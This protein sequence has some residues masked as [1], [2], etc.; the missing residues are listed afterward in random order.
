MHPKF[1]TQIESMENAI[2]G[3][4]VK[5]PNKAEEMKYQ[6]SM[7]LQNLKDKVIKIYYNE[8]QNLLRSLLIVLISACGNGA[9]LNSTEE[10][11]KHIFSKNVLKLLIENLKKAAAKEPEKKL[12]N[13]FK[14]Q[15][16]LQMI[17]EEEII[18]Q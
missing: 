18:L 9:E 17:Q 4:R 16:L 6:L 2:E 11:V 3:Y 7:L 12:D 13:R 15:F 5:F 10:L 1:F 14:Q 8:R